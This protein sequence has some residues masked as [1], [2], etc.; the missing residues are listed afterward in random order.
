MRLNIKKCLLTMV[1]LFVM[2]I[3]CY[4]LWQPLKVFVSHPELIQDMGCWGILAVIGA[5]FVQIVFAF[6]PG[7]MLEIMAGM[8]YGPWWGLVICMIGSFLGS[9]CIFLLVQK[10]GMPLIEKLFSKNQLKD[11]QYLK[12][13]KR[14]FSFM[15]ILFFIP[16]TPKDLLTYMMPL[17]K[18]TYMQ[19]AIITALARIPSV[20]TSTISGGLVGSQ[21]YLMAASVFVVTAII[22]FVGMCY[23][24]KKTARIM[25]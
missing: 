7:E 10:W 22:A 24:Q 20:L 18:L 19:F 14:L 12:N 5:V 16:G 3:G 8:I 15:F 6:L 25:R 9:T 21:D 2:G 23:Y 4:L 13:E 11:L 17:T 1:L